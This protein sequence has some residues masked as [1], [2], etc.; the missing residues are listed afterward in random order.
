M[1]TVQPGQAG[2][3]LDL[4]LVKQLSLTRSRIQQLNSRGQVLVN[5]NRVKSGYTLRVGDA[6][7]VSIPTVPQ[8]PQLLA[9]NIP[10]DVVYEDQHLLVINKA[11]GVVVHP[12]A[13]HPDKTLVNAVLY[14]CPDLSGIGAELRPGIV[15]RL[16]KDTTGLLVVAKSETAFDSLSQQIRARQVKRCYKAL[17]QGVVTTDQGT[18]DAPIGRHQTDRKR[19]TVRNDGRRAV[20]HYQVRSRMRRFSFL[21]CRLETGRTHQ[22][23]VHLAHLNHPIVGD[24]VYGFKTMNFGLM[25]QALHAANL[26]FFHPKGQWVEFTAPLP[27]DFSQALD[28]ARRM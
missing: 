12:A 6:V 20:T 17:V 23:R 25:G 24:L 10:L 7:E 28:R 26:G 2:Q 5:G 9:Q 3:R 22:I 4:W 15:H 27:Q 16:D 1:L 18:I 13:G 21:E 14:R 8:T 11:R 19:M